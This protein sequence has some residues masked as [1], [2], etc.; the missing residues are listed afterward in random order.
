MR[1]YM[2]IVSAWGGA[3]DGT[4]PATKKRTVYQPFNSSNTQLQSVPDIKA[5]GYTIR[6]AL[7]VH[8]QTLCVHVSGHKAR[9]RHHTHTWRGKRVSKDSGNLYSLGPSSEAMNT[10][11]WVGKAI[12]KAK[13]CSNIVWNIK[14]II[15][16]ITGCRHQLIQ[17]EAISCKIKAVHVKC[18]I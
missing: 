14:N 4:S 6:Q 3:R 16:I 10:P 11:T 15:I 13:L 18:L 1:W 7:P 17:K 8:T 5:K 9:S 2:C 12:H